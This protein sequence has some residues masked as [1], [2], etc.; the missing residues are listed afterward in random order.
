MRFTN[1]HLSHHRKPPPKRKTQLITIYHECIPRSL[2]HERRNELLKVVLNDGVPRSIELILH[3]KER[4]WRDVGKSIERR[5]YAWLKSKIQAV[6]IY[7]WK[8]RGHESGLCTH[9]LVNISI[10]MGW[11][12]HIILQEQQ[13]YHGAKGGKTSININ[14]N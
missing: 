9:V 7:V 5:V 11:L 1:T 8:K 4:A 6:R 12:M 2:D 14:T 13:L 10:T 3:F